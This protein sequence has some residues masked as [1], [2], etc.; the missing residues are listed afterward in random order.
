MQKITR[1]QFLTVAG[2]ATAVATLA[3]CSSDDT[4]ATTSTST[5]TSTSS[6]SSASE[7]QDPVTMVIHM[8]GMDED[9]KMQ[10]AMADIETDERFSHVTWEWHAREADFL[11]AVPIAIAAGTQVDV[12]IAANPILFQQ[13]ASEGMIMP[14]D[15]LFAEIGVDP[16]EQYGKYVENAT[17]EGE[18]YMV[19]H[20]IT[21][22]IL[23]Y[24]KAIFDAA[25]EPYPDGDIP[26]TWDTFRE[27]A[28]RITSG[29]GSDKVYGAF[30]L[31]WG[32]FWYGKAI[33]ALGGG[34]NFYNDEGLSNI[35]DPAFADSIQLTYDMMHVDGSMMTHANAK[36]S[37]TAATDIM[38]GK[39]GMG[40]SGAWVLPWLGDKETYPR[41]WK[42]GVA[43]MPVDEG[44][45]RK[46]WGIVNGFG[47]PPTSA[48]PALALEITVELCNLCAKYADATEEADRT[49]EQD[50]MFLVYEELLADDD[51]TVDMLKDLFMNEN[52][53]SVSEKITGTNCT[54]YETV[55]TEEVDKFLSQEQDMDTTIANIKSRGDAVITG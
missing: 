36:T 21:C 53:V 42:A 22:W 24:N 31:T 20:N 8:N 50:Q 32:T 18:I 52:T 19:P 37:Q 27:V 34:E 23:Y 54:E 40:I 3:A 46:T 11:T 15:D 12:V 39:Y 14:L 47:I 7:M 26:M 55:C 48:D 2:T 6:S 13:Y 35:E 33:M 9:Y 38:N 25:N 44:T 1:R 43:P 10:L 16:T 4:S 45:D 29:S 17:Y 51:I 30:Y 41:D 28:A 5:S 49:V